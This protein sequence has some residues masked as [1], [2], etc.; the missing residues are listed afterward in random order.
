VLAS[1]GSFSAVSAL[2][3][4]PIVGGVLMMEGALGFGAATIPILLPGFD[5]VPAAVVAATS[6]WLVMKT[7]ERRPESR[8]AGTP[9]PVPAVH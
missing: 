8:E 4:G 2:F 6:A 1:A 9:A 3:G 5:A 7:L